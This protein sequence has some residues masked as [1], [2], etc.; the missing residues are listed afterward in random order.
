MPLPVKPK[1]MRILKKTRLKILLNDMA[2]H[3]NQAIV[4][5]H[6][7]SYVKL[8]GNYLNKYYYYVNGLPCRLANLLRKCEC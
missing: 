8:R 2:G 3:I 5:F 1:N 7:S 4:I 6:S